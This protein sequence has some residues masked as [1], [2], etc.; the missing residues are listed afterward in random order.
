MSSEVIR[1]ANYSQIESKWQINSRNLD[2]AYRF[3]TVFSS[4]L[5]SFLYGNNTFFKDFPDL[6]EQDFEGDLLNAEEKKDQGALKKY[7][8]PSFKYTGQ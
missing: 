5:L 8:D 3:T 4:V 1:N 7:I 2:Q 6:L